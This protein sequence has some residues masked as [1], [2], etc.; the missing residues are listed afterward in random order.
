MSSTCGVDRK[1][2]HNSKMLLVL[3]LTWGCIMISSLRSVPKRVEGSERPYAALFSAVLFQ[4]RAEVQQDD[5]PSQSCSIMNSQRPIVLHM[6]NFWLQNHI[7]VNLHPRW[8][9]PLHPHPWGQGFGSCLLLHTTSL[10]ARNNWDVFHKSCTFAIHL[11]LG[12]CNSWEPVHFWKAAYHFK[13]YFT[14]NIKKLS[15]SS[16]EVIFILVEL[17]ISQNVRYQGLKYFT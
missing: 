1:P 2:E 12:R 16:C 4:M 13:L 15:H 9:S 17:V 14:F 7:S 10:M 6:L 8:C 5:P 11:T 3:S